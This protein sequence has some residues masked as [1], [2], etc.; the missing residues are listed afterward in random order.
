MD[1]YA[2]LRLLGT[3]LGGL[4]WVQGPGGN[5]SVKT[6]DQVWVKASGTRLAQVAENFSRVPRAWVLS[7]LAGD[8][9]A[10]Q[11]VFAVLPRPSLET[12]FHALGPAVVAH[13]HPVGVLL[14]ACSTTA[15]LHGV[16]RV[17]YERPGLGLAL[18]V[19]AQLG[20]L[21]SERAFI[22][23][24]HGLIVY[25]DSAE[26][27]IQLSRQIDADARSH[28]AD[29]P[30]FGTYAAAYGGAP[31]L[32]FDGG[33]ATQIPRRQGAHARYLFPDAVVY[34]SH[35]VAP[36]LETATASRALALLKRPAVLV[37]GNGNRLAIARN[38][39]QLAFATEVAAA[40]DWVQDALVPAG[41]ARYLP[42][43]EPAKILDLPSEQYRLRL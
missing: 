32:S 28:F 35:I 19:R 15:R 23:D 33:L 22:L 41:C 42:D 31:E 4:N 14:E 20:D 6:S 21:Q 11:A 17:P 39:E 18:A 2:E 3:E 43:D 40:H 29:L 7:A 10:E 1:A 27:A 37:D 12:Y 26:A 16:G 24:S 8:S 30:D 25:A 38:R 36:D 34:A 9:D 13:S 5:V